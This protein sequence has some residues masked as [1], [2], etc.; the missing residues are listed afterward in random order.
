MARAASAGADRELDAQGFQHVRAAAIARCR[1]VAVLGHMH[2]GSGHH[3]RHQRGDIERALA[4]A[5]G[6]AG[7]EQRNAGQAHIHRRRHFPHG[8]G[9]AD[10]F[11]HGRAFHPHRHQK[12]G[13]LRR[14]GLAGEYHVHGGKRIGLGQFLAGGD[15]LDVRKKRHAIFAYRRLA[16]Y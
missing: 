15:L 16:Q 6:A 4:I 12:C 3:E 8:A 1:T 2:A 13:D 10:Q 5:A 9:E 7:I 11:I 14:A